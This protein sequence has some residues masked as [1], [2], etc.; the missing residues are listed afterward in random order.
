VR[1]WTAAACLLAIV[2]AAAVFAA[3]TS[4]H[5]ANNGVINGKLS[6]GSPGVGSPANVD[7]V[8]YWAK[9]QEQQPDRT[10]KTNAQG[11]FEFAGLPVGPEYGYVVANLRQNVW[12]NTG[13]I[14]LTA[15]QPRQK[16]GL[17]VY[18]SNADDSTVRILTASMMLMEVDKTTQSISVLETY[19]VENRSK[20]TFLPTTEGPRGPMGLLRFSLPPDAASLR[21]MG[22]MSG[23]QVIQIDRGFATDMPVRP[24]QTEVTFTYRI[25]YRDE[26]GVYKFERTAPYPTAAFRLLRSKNGPNVTSPDLKLGPTAPLWGEAYT[27]LTAEKLPSRARMTI[28]ISDLPVNTYPLSTRNRW[29]WAGAAGS[30]L[31][32][33]TAALLLWHRGSRWDS[34]V[35]S[36][37]AVTSDAPPPG[38][39]GDP[40]PN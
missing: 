25:P 2:V 20:A 33:L 10:V 8:L 9:G 18:D 35:D 5:A 37:H 32:L 30:F 26:K 11:E 40:S 27:V 36:P 23:R 13:K 22:E 7:V 39:R 4:T 19:M 28:S 3:P 34:A 21:P 24:G 29:L 14:A 31:L 17:D 6:S 12:Y 38:G 16:V 15:A 1:S